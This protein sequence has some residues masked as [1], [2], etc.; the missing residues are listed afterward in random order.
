MIMIII[1][2]LLDGL[3]IDLAAAPDADARGR[4]LPDHERLH[5]WRKQYIY[6]YIYRE[7]YIHT[8]YIY[9]YIHYICVCIHIYIY[10]HII[11]IHTY[12]YTCLYIYI[13]IYIHTYTYTHVNALRHRVGLDEEERRVPQGLRARRVG[14]A[15]GVRSARGLGGARLLGAAGGLGARLGAARG[16]HPDHGVEGGPHGLA[17]RRR[18]LGGLGLRG[19]AR[20]RRR[21]G[22]SGGRRNGASQRAGASRGR[23][24]EDLDDKYAWLSKLM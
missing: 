9:I 8:L 12:M 2:L 4:Q 23:G 15:R 11:Y 10:I 1:L 5:A 24:G 21:L 22:L 17:R 19:L 18:R 13:Y 20:R 16:D 7:R 6:I 14:D 3:R